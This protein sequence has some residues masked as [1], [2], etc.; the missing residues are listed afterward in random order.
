MRRRWAGVGGPTRS[1]RAGSLDDQC[2]MKTGT[3]ISQSMSRVTPP[4]IS[5]SVREWP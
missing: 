4:R 1:C 5:S 2:D 3:V